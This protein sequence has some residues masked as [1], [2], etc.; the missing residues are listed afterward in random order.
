MTTAFHGLLLKFLHQSNL[1]V[2][3]VL[4]VSCDL[5]AFASY[6]NNATSCKLR[7]QAMTAFMSWWQQAVLAFLSCILA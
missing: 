3:Q 7:I 6:A 5:I 2:L 4:A 1:R